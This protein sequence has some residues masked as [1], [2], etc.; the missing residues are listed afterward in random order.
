MT[1]RNRPRSESACPGKADQKGISMRSL[2]RAVVIG[3]LALPLALGGAANAFACD[4]H[5]GHH[6][7]HCKHEGHHCKHKPSNFEFELSD[8]DNGSI[9]TGINHTFAFDD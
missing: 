9:V 2:S 4:K 5:E 8:D 3:A 1:A 7:Q 6:G